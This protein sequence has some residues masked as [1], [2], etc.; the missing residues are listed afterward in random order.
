[1]SEDRKAALR[2]GK[3]IPGGKGV[4]G[5][6]VKRGSELALDWAARQAARLEATDSRGRALEIA[7]PEGT[8]LRAGDVLVAEDGSL[9]RVTA[10]PQPVFA[11]TPCPEHGSPLDL[12]RAAYHLGGRHVA[13]VLEA[14]RLLVERDP[15]LAELLR[16]E[17]LTV[18]EATAAFEPESAAWG[19][20]GQGHAH[21]HAHHGHHHDHDHDHD[22]RHGHAHEHGHGH[23]HGHDHA[24]DHGH[25]HGHRADEPRAAGKPVGVQVVAAPHVHGPGCRHDHDHGHDHGHDHAHG[26]GHA[27]DH[28]HGHGHGH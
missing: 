27:H 14:D 12:L 21:G 11:V 13:L 8:A 24:H 20:G 28:G 9:V 25:H 7:L 15:A 26:H 17:H 2:V 6:L 4:S 23:G 18:T 16:S 10:A 3:R 22:H 19:T 1:M 5:V